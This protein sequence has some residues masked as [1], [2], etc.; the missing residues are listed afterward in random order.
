MV[1]EIASE[2]EERLVASENVAE[3]KTTRAKTELMNIVFVASECAPWSKT[4]GLADV[5]GS[6]P[7]ALAARGHRVMVI[8]PRY[9]FWPEALDTGKRISVHGAEVGFFHHT[10]KGC[11]AT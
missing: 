1:G 4:G 8:S 9:G 7:P 10:S 2:V 11:V 6:L 5:M 3:T